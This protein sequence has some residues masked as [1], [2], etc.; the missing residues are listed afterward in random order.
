MFKARQHDLRGQKIPRFWG[1]LIDWIA[2]IA[3]LEL[4][5]EQVGEL[6]LD[7]VRTLV[8]DTIEKH[9]QSP[10]LW[11]ERVDYDEWIAEMRS[12]KTVRAYCA[13]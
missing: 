7:D 12:A 11:Q 2:P 9:P 6:T 1:N 4:E 8:L 10:D 13:S 5:F 3:R